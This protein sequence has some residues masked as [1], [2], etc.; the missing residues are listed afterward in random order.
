MSTIFESPLLTPEQVSEELSLPLQTLANMRHLGTG[1]R[2]V[3][4]PNR[5]VRYF[6]SDVQAWVL[7]HTAAEE[8][9]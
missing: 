9:L 1:P 4:L 6:L 7:G 2:F 8:V 5:K 3:K